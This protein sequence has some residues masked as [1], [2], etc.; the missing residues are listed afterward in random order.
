MGAI[1]R[2]KGPD[3]VG[4]WGILQPMADGLK[5]VVKELIFPMRA[6]V[7]LFLAGPMVVF[8]VSLFGWIV[9]PQN[10]ASVFSSISVAVLFTFVVSGLNIYG[11]VLAGWASNS[12]YAFLGAIRATAQMISYELVFGMINVIVILFS[13][14]YNYVD[15]VL[16]Q[17]VGIF[18]FPLFPVFIIF[19]IVM[20]AETNR[21]P[22]DLAEAEAELVA[23]YNV[24]YS[25]MM[26]ALFFLGEYANMLLLSV[27]GALYFFGGWLP[28]IGWGCGGALW[29]FFK[30]LFFCIMFVWVRATLPRYR[31]DQLMSIGWK[32]LLPLIFGLF[33]FYV[34]LIIIGF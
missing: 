20:L 6:S 27:V 10:E 4:F 2:R 16:Q 8:I 22:F 18:V 31:Y 7:F 34:G 33:I 17:R 28:I 12:R 13:G 3:V 24:E 30:S 26:F 1:Q 5:L 29:L 14:S 32:I 21:T 15:I 11:L 23:G 19:L 9:I 25:S